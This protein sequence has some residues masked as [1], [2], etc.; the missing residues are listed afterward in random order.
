MRLKVIKYLGWFG[1]LTPVFCAGVFAGMSAVATPERT[2]TITLFILS[3]VNYQ[4]GRW[5]LRK[6]DELPT[7]VKKRA[8]I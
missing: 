4:F 6:L 5:M 2:F 3:V 7:K 8:N 1:I